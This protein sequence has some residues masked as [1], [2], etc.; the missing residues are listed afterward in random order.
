MNQKVKHLINR[1]DPYKDLVLVI[2][3]DASKE[4]T[5]ISKIGDTA[6]RSRAL[7]QIY[8]KAKRPVMDGVSR[9]QKDGLR[10]VNEMEGNP[11]LV[12]AG[13]VRAWQLLTNEQRSIVTDPKLELVPNELYWRSQQ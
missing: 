6:A 4:M 13:P 1:S 5:G 9:Y 8:W 7:D 10:V 2:F 11:S 12:V 3:V